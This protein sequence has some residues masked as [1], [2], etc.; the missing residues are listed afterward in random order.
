MPLPPVGTAPNRPVEVVSPRIQLGRASAAED[1]LGPSAEGDRCLGTARRTHLFPL[2]T[3][4]FT[5]ESCQQ[6]SRAGCCGERCSALPSRAVINPYSARSTRP[7]SIAPPRSL[8]AYRLSEGRFEERSMCEPTTRRAV[9]DR[10]TAPPTA[11]ARLINESRTVGQFGAKA[12]MRMA[13][14]APSSQ[15]QNRPAGNF[16][17]PAPVLRAR[18]DHSDGLDSEGPHVHLRRRDA[19][20]DW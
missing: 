14:V 4:F 6:R 19:C 12:F 16:S 1:R 11:T 5:R 9:R 2:T 15:G 20:L 13:I 7:A 8:S 17:I 10:A 18:G 3:I